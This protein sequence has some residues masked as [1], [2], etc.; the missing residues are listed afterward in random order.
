MKYLFSEAWSAEDNNSSNDK[1]DGYCKVG[2]DVLKAKLSKA[3]KI[4]IQ[5]EE[6]QDNKYKN[7]SKSEIT[8]TK[9]KN[10]TIVQE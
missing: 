3:I 4:T 1:K 7:K 2:S 9:R 6:I 5:R 10:K 8:T